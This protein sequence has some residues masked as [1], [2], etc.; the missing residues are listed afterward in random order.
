MPL[1]RAGAIVSHRDVK[2]P[3]FEF[4]RKFLNLIYGVVKIRVIAAVNYS[5]IN[6]RCNITFRA[7]DH[8]KSVHR[9]T[10]PGDYL[11]L[12]LSSDTREKHACYRDISMIKRF[13]SAPTLSM[14][15]TRYLNLYNATNQFLI[16]TASL[17]PEHIESSD[18]R[19]SRNAS[20]YTSLNGLRASRLMRIDT[21]LAN[22]YTI[23]CNTRYRIN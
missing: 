6:V 22:R 4:S 18:T 7:I 10:P 16:N 1:R 21:S 20:V 5:G 23:T 8:G 19:V 2:I 3:T 14:R 12:F 15:A 17:N 9:S 13:V 11:F